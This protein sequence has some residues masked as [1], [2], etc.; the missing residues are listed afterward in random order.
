MFPSES[1]IIG[2]RSS[3]G[4]AQPATSSLCSLAIT[5]KEYPAGSL[6][7][8]CQFLVGD[9]A[10]SRTLA[11]LPVPVTVQGH[12]RGRMRL[13]QNDCLQG[14]KE[15]PKES[16]DLSYLHNIHKVGLFMKYESHMIVTSRA[17]TIPKVELCCWRSAIMR[18]VENG[19]PPPLQR[20]CVG[21]YA[22]FTAYAISLTGPAA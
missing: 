12:E 8:L 19:K 13:G 6:R 22:P 5:A 15:I 2:L 9:F 11:L 21:Y 17:T 7:C 20:R 3:I 4:D 16:S 10:S 18:S 14:E 1:A